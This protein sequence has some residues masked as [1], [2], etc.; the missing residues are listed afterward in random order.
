M[1]QDQQTR[2]GRLAH[3]RPL[4]SARAVEREGAEDG[5]ALVDLREK[6][7]LPLMQL[8]EA[9]HDG[10]AEAGATV[11]TTANQR[12]IYNLSNGDLFFDPDGTGVVAATQIANLNRFNPAFPSDVVSAN[13]VFPNLVSSDFSL[14]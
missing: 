6:R 11:A 7:H 2:S 9:L 14:I 3:V 5:G 1:P 10:E 12:F 8:D 4:R 13:A